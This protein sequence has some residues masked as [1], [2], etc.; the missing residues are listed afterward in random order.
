MEDMV[1]YL[2]RTGMEEGAGKSNCL[3]PSFASPPF[4]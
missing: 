1:C 3:A 2:T 4:L